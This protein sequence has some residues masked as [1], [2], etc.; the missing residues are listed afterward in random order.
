MVF[1]NLLVV[2]PGAGE[3]AE[4]ARSRSRGQSRKAQLRLAELRAWHDDQFKQVAAID[5]VHVPYKGA[6]P[7]V[8]GLIGGPGFDDVRQAC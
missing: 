2:S 7:A 5:I 4:G 3:F 6:A 1:A 8:Q